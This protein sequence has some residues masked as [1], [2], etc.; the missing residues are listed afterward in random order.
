[1]VGF[2]VR[3]VIGVGRGVFGGFI[4]FGVFGATHAVG[5]GVFGGFV[6]RGVG[7]PLPHPV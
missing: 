2:G 5:R 3:I 7:R 4:G 6:G 1:L